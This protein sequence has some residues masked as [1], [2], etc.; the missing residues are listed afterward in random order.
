MLESYNIRL[1]DIQTSFARLLPVESRGV[2][3]K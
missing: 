1:R 2:E 3:A